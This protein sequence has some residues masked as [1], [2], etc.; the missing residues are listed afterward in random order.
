MRTLVFLLVALSSY[1]DLQAAIVGDLE[2]CAGNAATKDRFGNRKTIRQNSLLNEKLIE[3]SGRDNALILQ[4]LGVYNR[5]NIRQDGE[6]NASAVQQSGRR[7]QTRVLQLGGHNRVTI[8][9][10]KP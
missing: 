2:P 10:D 3:Q 5:G 6:C 4:Q 9:Q 1:G 8:K 7:N